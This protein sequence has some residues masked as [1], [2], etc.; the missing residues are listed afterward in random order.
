MVPF[1][2]VDLIITFLGGEVRKCGVVKKGVDVVRH[3]VNIPEINLE[4]IFE[5]FSGST[6]VGNDR[7]HIA[8]HGFQW[9]YSKRLG[10][11]RHDVNVRQ[12]KHFL[13][14]RSTQETGE[15]ETVGYSQAGGMADAAVHH[16][17]ASGHHEMYVLSSLEDLGGRLDEILGA[18]LESDPAQEGNHLVLETPLHV[19]ILP[20]A[21][22]HRVVD[23]N[24]LVRGY[25]V[26]VDNN[27]AG[28]IADR[29]DPVGSL[30]SPLLYVFRQGK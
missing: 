28:Q 18:F 1:Q 16:V 26:L 25:A 30:H 3:G 17:T 10:N 14:I 9:R 27:V 29:D 12:S 5:H 13:D 20:A 6:L 21:E 19:E 7:R 22:I 2:A 11:R 24:H 23:R 8:A 15:M 4:S